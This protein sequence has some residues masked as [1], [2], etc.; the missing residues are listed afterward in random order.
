MENYMTIQQY[1][2]DREDE[3]F[4]IYYDLLMVMKD[5][6]AALKKDFEKELPDNK[7]KSLIRT[8][9]VKQKD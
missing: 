2:R 1:D 5:W 4:L 7:A 9:H 8:S 6:Y 3:V